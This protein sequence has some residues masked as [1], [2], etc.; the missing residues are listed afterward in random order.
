MS[1]YSPGIPFSFSAVAKP[2]VTYIFL[3]KMPG[4]TIPTEI[5][6]MSNHDYTDKR[7]TKITITV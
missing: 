1:N 5:R 3:S 6:D 2:G 4:M 7:G